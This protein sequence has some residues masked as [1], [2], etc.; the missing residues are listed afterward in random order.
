MAQLLPTESISDV[1]RVR[2]SAIAGEEGGN[3]D[4]KAE[5]VDDFDAIGSVER[6]TGAMAI[7]RKY[8]DAPIAQKHIEM[9]AEPPHLL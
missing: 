2:N 9:P 5:S 6:I 3:Y 4:I 1:D 7:F 8:A